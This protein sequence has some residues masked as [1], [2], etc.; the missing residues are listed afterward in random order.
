MTPTDPLPVAVRWDK[1]ALS[2][3]VRAEIQQL[4]KREPVHFLVQLA[5]AWAVIVGAISWALVAQSVWVSALAVF[6]VATRQNLLGLLVHEQAHCLAFKARWGDLFVDLTAANALLVLTVGRYAQVHLSHHRFYFTPRDPDFLR[7]S[8]TD[9]TIPM[10]ASRL[11]K[12][13][14][15]DLLGLNLV[16]LLKSKRTTGNSRGVTLFPRPWCPGW[17]RPAYY[18]VAAAIFTATGSWHI[19]LLFWLLP[20]V[21]VGQ[22][23]VRLGAISEHK[24]NLPNAAVEE[25]SPLIIPVWWEKLL[26]PNLN[27]TL[28]AYHHFFPGIAFCHLPK[29]HQV[30]RREGL[31][32]EAHVFHGYLPFLS[33]MVTQEKRASRLRVGAQG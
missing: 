8:G 2:S 14:L 28:H 23:I 33:F 29:V 25:S 18:L 22:V 26:L 31:V 11:A 10:T 15:T 19:F 3:Q 32:N 5:L 13:F 30:F 20:L 16:K 12:L 17:V 9:W 6:L 24:Y 4:I 27:F 1:N 7:K 21:T